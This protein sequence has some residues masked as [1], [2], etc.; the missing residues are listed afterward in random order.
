MS[1]NP[2]DSD[3]VE[4]DTSYTQQL[5]VRNPAPPRPSKRL[6]R[7]IE[8][9]DVE[10]EKNN[11]RRPQHHHH[12]V[13]QIT[14]ISIQQQPSN[15]AATLVNALNQRL[16]PPPPPS[17]P[18]P[19]PLPPSPPPSPRASMPHPAANTSQ[20]KQ[21]EFGCVQLLDLNGLDD[22][23][24]WTRWRMKF[25]GVA[26]KL[27]MMRF[28]A[29][30]DPEILQD[31]E[32]T[33]LHHSTALIARPSSQ[34]LSL[35]DQQRDRVA[36][37]LQVDIKSGWCG[38][39]ENEISVSAKE[40]FYHWD[41]ILHFAAKNVSTMN[42]VSLWGAIQ[43]MYEILI[44]PQQQ[45]LTSQ[46]WQS[47]IRAVPMDYTLNQPKPPHYWSLRAIHDHFTKHTSDATFSIELDIKKYASISQI[48]KDNLLQM[49]DDGDELRVRISD[50]DVKSMILVDQHRLQLEERVKASRAARRAE[51]VQNREVVKKL[52][53]R[54]N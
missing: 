48:M 45:R 27:S 7:I 28:R 34:P 44:V 2:F 22:E 46:L 31:F 50:K 15:R 11:D 13:L 39:C 8:D 52:R 38:A 42:L 14:S 4:H 43:D 1:D 16:A 10:D 3:D 51:Q 49:N 54:A 53:L 6:R 12:S 20:Y 30:I 32:T 40:R 21:N 35:T 37:W 36:Y 33:V 47:Q 41:T 24:F 5:S 17:P 26:P 23:L 18:P 25:P 19:P 29:E 9:D